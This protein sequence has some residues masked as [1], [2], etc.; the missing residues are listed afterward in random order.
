M[1]PVP[2]EKFGSLPTVVRLEVLCTGIVSRADIAYCCCITVA[3][4]LHSISYGMCEYIAGPTNAPATYHLFLEFPLP[5]KKDHASNENFCR[6]LVFHQL[7]HLLLL[8]LSATS[9][10]P[11]PPAAATLPL[12]SLLLLGEKDL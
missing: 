3:L 4:P 9:S 12:P 2:F 10:L 7:L 8:A 11:P 6:Q 5:T 1:P